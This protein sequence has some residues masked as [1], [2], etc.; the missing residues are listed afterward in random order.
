MCKPISGL[1]N[2]VSLAIPIEASLIVNFILM[3][4]HNLCMNEIFQFF[5]EGHFLN[6]TRQIS[7]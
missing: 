2:Y 3:H 7:I 1:T 5:L 6:Y 4:A